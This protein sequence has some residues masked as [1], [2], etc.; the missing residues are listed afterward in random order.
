MKKGFTL[1]EMVVALIVIAIVSVSVTSVIQKVVEVDEYENKSEEISQKT[2]KLALL[3][4]SYLERS[5]SSSVGIWS[6]GACRSSVVVDAKEGIVLTPLESRNTMGF[7]THFDEERVIDSSN[8][9]EVL[10]NELSSLGYGTTLKEGVVINPFEIGGCRDFYT[11][12]NGRYFSVISGIEKNSLTTTTPYHSH[13][14]MMATRSL[15]FVLSPKGDVEL[16][17][18]FRPWLSL[19]FGE[20]VIMETQISVLKVSSLGDKAFKVEVC[21]ET[22]GEHS[23]LICSEARGYYA[24]P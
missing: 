2:Q 14:Y 22:G 4:S 5:L 7:L 24:N 20:K 8:D 13:G 16:Y 11:N 3:I 1:L 23:E 18:S 17:P 6:D 19:N 21:G 12:K 15:M 9:F 10:N